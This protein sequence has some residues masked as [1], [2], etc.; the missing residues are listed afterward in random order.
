MLVVECLE[1]IGNILLQVEKKEIL[2]V[3]CE[4]CIRFEPMNSEMRLLQCHALT[5]RGQNHHDS[6]V[7]RLH[8]FC[9]CVNIRA[10][11]TTK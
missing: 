4:A 10:R 3:N 6:V 7:Y 11:E 1:I 2:H 5:T 9:P 8:S